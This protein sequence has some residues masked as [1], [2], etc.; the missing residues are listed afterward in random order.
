MRSYFCFSVAQ[1]LY[2]PLTPTGLAAFR[3]LASSAAHTLGAP[4]SADRLAGPPAYAEAGQRLFLDLTGVLRNRVGRVLMPR[5]LDMME[6]RSARVLRSLYDRPEFSVIHTS[7]R[8][9]LRR[10]A[11]IAVRYRVPVRLVQAVISPAAA[12]RRVVSTGA[13]LAGRLADRPGATPAQRLD[14]VQT[15][16][17]ADSVPLVPEIVP[18]A[19]AGVA[20]F[21]LAARLLRSQITLKGLPHNV[22]T[23]M[24]LELWSLTQRVRADDDAAAALRDTAAGELARR[25]GTGRLPPALQTGLADFLARYGHRAVAEIDVGLPRWSEDPTHLLGVLANY[26]RLENP[27]MAPD[28]V[29]ERSTREAM[30]MVDRLASARIPTAPWWPASTGSPPSSAFRWPPTTCRPVTWRP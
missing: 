17:F 28:V 24:D 1:G 10:A 23:E 21:G 20:M 4:E 11:R 12:H 29:F 30:Q 2:R 5:V 27:D 7:P 22:T 25:Y 26:L 9:A 16:L 3:L 8:P 15:I 13:T 18:G 6:T 14:H 19:L